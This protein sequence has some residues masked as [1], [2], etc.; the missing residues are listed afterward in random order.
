MPV[1]PYQLQEMVERV[2]R[3]V[4]RNQQLCMSCGQPMPK[5]S[6]CPNCWPK[7]SEKRH[8][9]NREVDLHDQIEAECRRQG[10]Y[11]RHARMD[12]KTT[13]RI[14]VPD[15]TIALPGGRTA[16]IECKAKGGKVS[17]E[18]A[19]AIAWLCKLGHIAKAVW[20]FEEFLEAVK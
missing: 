14:G 6:E 9:V 8:G 10:W 20:S 11:Y 2:A 3:N 12:K 13:E 5:D 7:P 1:T 4:K 19:A 17:A 18:Q 15:F 16:W